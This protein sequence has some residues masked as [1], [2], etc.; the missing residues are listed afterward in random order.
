MNTKDKR[1]ER[2]RNKY[3]A[4][5]GQTTL[6]GFEQQKSDPRNESPKQLPFQNNYVHYSNTDNLACQD[7]H[8]NYTID[9]YITENQELITDL[10]ECLKR[11]NKTLLNAPLGAGKTTLIFEN[12]LKHC[13]ENDLMLV[14]C[15][16]NVSMIN[17][18]EL[19]MSN[20]ELYT[21]YDKSEQDKAQ[22][23]YNK[24]PIMMSTPD[25]IHKAIANVSKFILVVD[26]AHELYTTSSY[27][28]KFINILES[29]EH[30]DAVLYVTATANNLVLD[31]IQNVL[32]VTA[33]NKL[34]TNLTIR[35][36]KTR[37]LTYVQ[38]QIEYYKNSKYDKI[39][40]Y[41][42]QS[43][44]ENEVL[45]ENLQKKGYTVV[46]LNSEKKTSDAYKKITAGKLPDQE[47]VIHTGI[48]QAG[49]NIN[50][51][52]L[53]ICLLIDMSFGSCPTAETV[54]QLVGRY[55]QNVEDTILLKFKRKIDDNTQSYEDKAKSNLQFA[56]SL[57]NLLNIPEN[58]IKLAEEIFQDNKLVYKNK[59]EVYVINPIK[60]KQ[61]A[62]FEAT[63]RTMGN[64]DLLIERLKSSTALN[65][66]NITVITDDEEIIPTD[67]D[68][69]CS[70]RKKEAKKIAMEE[71]QEIL[72]K[73][74][75]L[76]VIELNF[77]MH[78]ET[79]SP[80]A[81][82]EVKTYVEKLLK[83]LRKHDNILS[84]IRKV[85]KYY[86]KGD[87]IEAIQTIKNNSSKAISSLIERC[88][89]K[90]I[91]H[92]LVVNDKKHEN[93]YKELNEI[94]N[95][96]KKYTEEK[97]LRQ[98]KIFQIIRNENILNSNKILTINN[99]KEIIKKLEKC[100]LYNS[101]KN[102]DKKVREITKLIENMYETKTVYH[103]KKN[104]KGKYKKYVD[105]YNLKGIQ[106]LDL[107]R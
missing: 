70:T 100:N 86:A 77:V 14:V 104:K 51:D 83:L 29:E 5:T 64:T 40:Y 67:I 74:T 57:S 38:Q 72:T 27:R 88:K 105:G 39:V 28:D 34:Q 16:P 48:M 75:K 60:C 2:R 78:N 20:K 45:A 85:E 17:Q 26:E 15:T 46:T 103:K 56:K 8:K 99:I 90:V 101:D 10:T 79:C 94:V 43:K 50:N 63:Q 22:E 89:I 84:S 11:K 42:N 36:A 24:Q 58:R 23:K 80:F 54:E 92:H 3:I 61:A 31:N 65:F 21:V 53:K 76:D 13:L 7:M 18:F 97:Y 106:T 73:L 87:W 62:Y 25:S 44:E 1:R 55:R 102:L 4:M 96:E 82:K 95:A 91:N 71:I 68:K 93:N 33:K 30:A 32:T 98:I 59:S 9:K 12:I 19:T 49:V 69:E 81:T 37:S 107:N 35:E 66:L 47:I 6:K 41:S 52:N